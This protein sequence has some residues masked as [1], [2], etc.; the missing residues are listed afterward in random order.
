MLALIIYKYYIPWAHDSQKYH[1]YQAE[2]DIHISRDDIFNYQPLRECNI[3]LIIPNKASNPLFSSIFSQITTMVSDNNAQPFIYIC[4]NGN[5]SFRK[6]VVLLELVTNVPFY[7]LR[8]K[9]WWRQT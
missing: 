1:D 4:M 6:S 2:V 7:K 8:H 3:Y 9:S 5:K